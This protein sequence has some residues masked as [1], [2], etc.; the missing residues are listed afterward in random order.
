MNATEAIK[1]ASVMPTVVWK[2]YVADL[3]DEEMMVRP[4]EGANHIKWQLGHLIA[5]EHGLVNAV[6]PRSMPE[7]PEGFAEKYTKETA[8]SDDPAAFDSKDDL[9]RLA[10]ASIAAATAAL[11]GLSDDDL[12]Q[13]IPERFQMFGPTVAHLFTMLPCHWIMHAGQW[14]VIRRKLGKPPLF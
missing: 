10:D 12:E 9:I 3:T 4:A 11:E 2:A 8:A 1:A 14:A 6:C 7:L 13:P 5:S